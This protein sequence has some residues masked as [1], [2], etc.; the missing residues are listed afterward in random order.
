V[1]AL[2]TTTGV[3]GVVVDLLVGYIGLAH[4]VRGTTSEACRPTFLTGIL[5][6]SLVRIG[7]RLVGSDE[8][9]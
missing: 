1:T 5:P 8:V 4:G 7:S 9:L 2:A 3:I 6:M